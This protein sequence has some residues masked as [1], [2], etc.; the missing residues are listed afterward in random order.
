[1]IKIIFNLIKFEHLEN[2]K[3][4]PNESKELIREVIQEY[5]KE[6]AKEDEENKSKISIK[7]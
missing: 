5:K 2:K 6:F 7:L 3:F 1:M 4:D